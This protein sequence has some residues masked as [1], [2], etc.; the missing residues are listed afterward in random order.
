MAELRFNQVIQG[1]CLNVIKTF[2]E[3]SVDLILCDPPYGIGF[4]NANWDLDLP[5]VEIWQEC[6]RVLKPGSFMFCMTTPRQDCFAE[7]IVRLKR[8]GFDVSHSPI[9]WAYLSGFP[10]SLDVA[11]NIDLKLG[12]ERPVAGEVA[13]PGGQMRELSRGGRNREKGTA[14]TGIK[15]DSKPV[16]PQAEAF[17]GW[18]SPGLKPAAEVIVVAMR[19]MSEK[20]YAS[21]ALKSLEDGSVGMGCFN[22]EG[23]RIPWASDEEHAVV[24]DRLDVRRNIYKNRKCT[25]WGDSPIYRR[26]SSQAGR[27]PANLL[28]SGN[29]LDDGVKRKAGGSRSSDL[30]R[31]GR[32]PIRPGGEHQSYGDEGSAGRSFDLDLWWEKMVGSLPDKV[33]RTFPFLVEPKPS[34]A[35]RDS[36]CENL[37]WE[38]D[39]SEYGYHLVDRERWEELGREEERIMSET[40]EPCRL[41]ARGN[42]HITVKPISLFCY[43]LTLASKPGQVVLD[44]FAG[45]G[46]TGVAAKILNRRYMLI[47]LHEGNC[48]IARRRVRSSGLPLFEGKEGS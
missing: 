1:N 4:S 37:F 16:T 32:G 29:A 38:L 45:S 39:E 8:A 36:G 30:G 31:T 19:P 28:V 41:R 3:K 26:P 10:K 21:Q 35:E 42:I 33:R 7:L 5:S 40:G 44:P 9:F 20:D 24:Q 15:Y 27:Y 12:A 48:E 6:L 13:Q 18:R 46:T 23:C 17:S 47:D 14:W 22:I 34:T 43:L 25:F 11:L 2:P